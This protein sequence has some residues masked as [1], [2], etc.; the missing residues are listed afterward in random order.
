MKTFRN[1]QQHLIQFKGLTDI[2]FSK[3]LRKN[4]DITIA[5]VVK[6]PALAGL[7]PILNESRMRGNTSFQILLIGMG[8]DLNSVNSPGEKQKRMRLQ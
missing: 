4:I 6:L 5:C 8:I 7:R 3:G 1:L 2:A